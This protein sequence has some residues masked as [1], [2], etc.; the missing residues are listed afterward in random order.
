MTA[1]AD[2][3]Q[4]VGA[5]LL[6][7]LISCALSGV[8][9]IQS[10]FY[11]RFYRKDPAAVKALVILIWVLD[12]I[13][14]VLACHGVWTC[15]ILNFGDPAMV[16]YIP[17]SIGL[18]VAFTAI[19]TFLV[20]VL[21]LEIIQVLVPPFV[22][23]TFVCKNLNFMGGIST[24]D[25]IRW[26]SFDTFVDHLAW[27]FTLGLSLSSAT[28]IIITLSMCFYLQTSRTGF[29]T[30]DHI[31]N[32][33]MIYTVN[34]GA[35]TCVATV[36]SL[37]FWLKMPYNRIFF[38]MHFSITKLY[39]L[40]LL[41]TLN[42]RKSVL[43]SSTNTSA[44]RASGGRGANKDGIALSVRFPAS[45]GSPRTPNS[46]S[47]GQFSS[48]HSPVE[49]NHY[50]MD[51]SMNGAISVAVNVEKTVQ[52]DYDGEPDTLAEATTKDIQVVAA[53]GRG[54]I[55]AVPILENVPNPRSGLMRGV[56]MGEV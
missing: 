41:S 5:V 31:I 34:N 45:P 55:G 9:A 50:P 36:L 4:T 35:I 22:V 17:M 42:T 52:Y 12:A 49:S 40:S 54:D 53:D 3:R 32:M 7:C 1:N 24:H 56:R 19:V 25:M 37:I 46:A 44:G 51:A 39:A 27:C 33:I 26:K 15:L 29:Q 14:T 43:A 21:C 23:A 8:V 13:H 48:L 16:D 20:Q 6:G 47:H 11:F 30:L 10:F 28:D 38:G 18:T 2:V